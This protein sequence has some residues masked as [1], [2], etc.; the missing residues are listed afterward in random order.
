MTHLAFAVLGVV[1]VGVWLIVG[2]RIVV[3]LADRF[4]NRSNND[5]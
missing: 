4:E 5:D 2:G 3:R 1:G